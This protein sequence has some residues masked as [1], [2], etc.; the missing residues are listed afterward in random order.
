MVLCE[1]INVESN[2]FHKIAYS[3]IT[4]HS[5]GGVRTNINH[6]FIHGN[7]IDSTCLNYGIRVG[8]GGIH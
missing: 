2:S 1:F 4:M 5:S 7:L 3:A 8:N 6:A